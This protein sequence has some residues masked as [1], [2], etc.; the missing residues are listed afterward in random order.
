MTWVFPLLLLQTLLGG[1]DNLWH[2]EIT[3]RLPAKRSASGE[4][5]LHATREF[6]YSV[7]LLLLAWFEPRGIWTCLLIVLLALEIVITLADFVV[8]DRTRRLP[9]LERVLHTILAIN[10]GV[11][12][13]ALTPA[14][15]TWWSLPTQLVPVDHGM[16][17][18]LFSSIATGTFLWSVRNAIAVR[19]L[20]RPPEWVRN[21]IAAQVRPS[22]HTVLVSGATGFIGGHLVR[23]L[24]A[25]GDRVIVLT[26]DADRALDRFGPHVRII[27]K[28]AEITENDSIDAVVNLAGEPILGFPWTQARR[29]KLISSRVAATWAVIE[30]CGRLSRPPRVLVS[31]SAIGYYGIGSKDELLDEKCN[32]ESIFQ[33]RLCQ[34]WEGTADAAEGLVHR[35]VKMRI[36][37]V[38]GRDGGA[39][40][41]LVKPM[42]WGLGALL[43]DGQQWVSWIHIADLVR[44]FEFAIDT[45]LLRGPVNA[46]SPGAVRHR[47][48][49]TLIAK[50]VHR[51]L[52]ARIPAL[53]I[54]T[55]LG[56][57]SQLLVDGQ[58]VTPAR[59]TALGFLFKHPTI[60]EALADLLDDGMANIY[61]WSL[62]Q[63]GPAAQASAVSSSDA[64]A[65]TNSAVGS[66]RT[67]GAP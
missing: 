10:F 64:S 67:R 2:H 50:V 26:R 48:M 13:S 44:L 21:P 40:P 20:R 49:Q 53:V 51:P 58:R 55:A 24:L 39:L 1:F 22:G 4:L 3:E 12:L 28:A 6:I 63:H 16:Y 35:I 18:W 62:G 36:G 19:R 33:S 45:P 59:A 5:A 60:G 17:S 23:H 46:V 8:E 15:I 32:P 43:G 42:R 47:Q 37:L 56:E 57:M 30:I 27:T 31:A 9:P 14:L 34:E 11:V 41:Q 52:W 66:V 61:P 25:R 65:R 38:L 54:R 7:V 29:K